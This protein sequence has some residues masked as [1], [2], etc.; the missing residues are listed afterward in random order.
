MSV[1]ALRNAASVRERVSEAEWQARVEL[2][3]AHR[4]LAHY[5]VNDLTYNHLSLRVPDEPDKLLIKPSDYSFDEVTASSLLKYD[6]E[7]NPAFEENPRLRGGGLVIHAGILKVRPDIAAVFHTHTPA[8]MG[9]SAH[10]DG[11]LPLTQHS[12]RFY[13]RIKYHDFGGFEFDP[14]MRD[15]LIK[16]LG[17]GRW[18]LLRNHGALVCGRTLREAFTDHH[19]L[20]MACRGQIAA[21]SAGDGNYVMPPHEVCVFARDQIEK[22]AH[23]AGDKDW[24]AVMRLAERL[25]PG[26]RE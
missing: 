25:D 13:E 8:A 20:E 26:F 21:L 7:G 14:R 24:P 15:P 16:D 12:M 9:V 6:F 17:D 23:S 5:G 11:L 22:T 3:A 10:K 19:M 1:T 18:A 4:G 2:A